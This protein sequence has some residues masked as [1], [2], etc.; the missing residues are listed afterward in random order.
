MS[1][2]I[3]TNYG[4]NDN[5]QDIKQFKLS[6]A[7]KGSLESCGFGI[8][9]SLFMTEPLNVHLYGCCA[10]THNKKWM[11]AYFSPYVMV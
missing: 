4:V 3:V 8:I 9:I 11:L 2:I 7:S 10:Y 6:I 1:L 5:G